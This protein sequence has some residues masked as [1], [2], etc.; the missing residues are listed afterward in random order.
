MYYFIAGC[1]RAGLDSRVSAR[2][3]PCF[4][5]VVCTVQVL[6]PGGT[7]TLVLG[8]VLPG[9]RWYLGAAL[10]GLGAS[11]FK[12]RASGGAALPLAVP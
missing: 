11:W 12:V 3:F 6:V 9:V 5:T 10:G 1:F 4:G 2:G 7:C 8:W